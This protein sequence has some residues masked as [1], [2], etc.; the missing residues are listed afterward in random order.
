MRTNSTVEGAS[1]CECAHVL[2]ITQGMVYK[3][4]ARL[5]YVR[6]ESS[7]EIK[8][9]KQLCKRGTHFAPDHRKRVTWT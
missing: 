1:F 6:D 4:R 9:T 8:S 7:S 5:N 2:R 3:P